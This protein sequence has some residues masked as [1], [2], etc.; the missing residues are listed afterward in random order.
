MYSCCNTHPYAKGFYGNTYLNHEMCITRFIEKPSNTQLSNY[1]M[2]GSYLMHKKRLSLFKR[3]E[4]EH[5]RI[6]T[7]FNKKARNLCDS[8]G[9]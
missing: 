6:D 5:G 1:V 7:V 3:S 2:A 4:W 8:L 9:G